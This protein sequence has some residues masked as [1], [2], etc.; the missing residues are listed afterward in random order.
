MVG[1]GLGAVRETL[2][3]FFLLEQAERK[4]ATLT[5]SRLDPARAYEEA[6]RCRRSAARAFR[7]P[8]EHRVALSLYRS[9]ALLQVAA[10][11]VSRDPTLDLEQL[12]PEELLERLG[13]AV[14]GPTPEIESLRR[15]VAISDP[16]GIE[17]LP[18]E[19]TLQAVGSMEAATRWLSTLIEMRAPAHLRWIGRIRLTGAALAALLLTVWFARWMLSPPNVALHRPARASSTNF[20]TQPSGAVDGETNGQFGYCSQPEDQPWLSIDLERQY[21]IKKVRIWGRGD[22]CYDQSIPLVLEVSDDSNSYRPVARRTTSFS[23]DAPWNVNLDGVKARFV[24]LR[25]DRHGHLVLGEVAVYG[26]PAT[27]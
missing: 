20:D 13:G 26:Y 5:L 6:A 10:F 3:E 9:A 23:E 17:R 18:S 2:R 24:R 15:V 4:S 19:A 8:A 1:P 21:S 12:T 7:D 14:A 27:K 11:L 22:C 25:A 16:F